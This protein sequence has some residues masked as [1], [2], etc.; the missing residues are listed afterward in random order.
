V[1]AIATRIAVRAHAPR[2]RPPTDRRRLGSTD[3]VL[4]LDTETRTDAAQALLFGSYQVWRAGHLRQEGLF[5]GD[6]TP[7]ELAVLQRYVQAHASATSGHLRLLTR[8]AFVRR[9]FLPLAAVAGARVVGF[10]LPFDLSRI[11]CGWRPSDNGGFT[12]WLLDSVDATGKRWPDRF[13]PMIRIKAL[14][15]R[16]NFISFAPSPQLDVR[17]RDGKH[18]RRGRFLDLRTLSYTFT[19]RKLSLDGAA[20]EF[21]LE[22]R[23]AQVEEHGVLTEEYVDYNRQDV[24]VTWRLHQALITEWEQHAIDLAP[25]EGYSPAAISKAYLQAMGVSP[26]IGRSTVPVERLGQALSAYF[27][28][29]TECRIRGVALPV[30]Y[31]D[32]ASM[33][34]TVFALLHLWD[35]V[36]AQTLECEDATDDARAIAERLDRTA[37]HDPA[38]WPQL[39]GVFCRVRPNAEL[40]PTRARYGAMETDDA[41]HGPQSVAWTIGLNRLRSDTELWFSLADV[42]AA[43]LLGGRA[44][45]ILEAFRVRPVGRLRGLK[46]IRLRGGEPVDPRRTDV[47]RLATEERAR[48]KAD[49]RLPRAEVTRRAQFLKTFANGGAYGIFAEVRQLDPVAGGEMVSAFGLD[50]LEARVGTPEEPGAFSFP[51]LAATITGTSRL[52]LG[53]AQADIEARGGSYVACDTDSLLIVSSEAGGLMPCPGGPE[54]LPDGSDAVRALAW[55]EVDEV[56]A[57]LEPLNPYAPGTVPRLIK[58]EGENFSD[59]GR[60]VELW[61]LASSSKRYVLYERADPGIVVRKPSEHG[62]GL[63]RTPLE[64][65]SDWLEDWPEWVDVVWRRII[66]AAESRESGPEPDW[67]AL[68]AISQV[69]VSS[70]A[71]MAPFRVAN[72]GKPYEAQVK[73]FGFLLLGHLDRLAPLPAGLDADNLT[74]V[75]PFTSKPDGLLGLA[76]RNRH[77]YQ[78]LA[79]TTKRGG[80]RGKVRLQ[81][82]GDVVARYRLHPEHKSGDPRGGLGRRGSVGLLPRLEVHAVGYPHHIGKE[83]NR[84]DDVNDGLVST[85]GEVYV[86]Y[87]D[88]RREWEAALPALLALRNESGWRYL[89][90][91]SG[92]S[93]RALRYALNGGMVPRLAARTVLRSLVEVASS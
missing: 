21:G 26:P 31:V 57:G 9:V 44:P 48:L 85:A 28:G 35:W 1:A 56:L 90:D 54:Q 92:L 70:P 34:P 47:F 5:Y 3:L 18:M 40:L 17:Y 33:Y 81:T 88:E 60:P 73:P 41:D 82:V 89:A 24:T 55:A 93:E 19:D 29:R 75:A 30:R 58:L 50:P 20:A 72:E 25:E 11:A 36:V 7:S 71:V 78:P 77:D 83:S 51:P 42:V 38:V 61:A 84:L 23:K 53:L 76:W 43:K 49:R 68:P 87:R 91:A 66:A 15:S 10:N 45:A 32:F 74:P 37:L 65:R 39:A 63:Y 14:D 46:P 52:L 80:A 64:R 59:G 79:V 27:G 13:K 6:L 12:L 4:V 2:T 62:L 16:R 86:E 8:E 22:V 67:F 69:P